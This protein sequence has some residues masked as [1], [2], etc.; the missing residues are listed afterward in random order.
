MD[1]SLPLITTLAIAFGF[2]LAFGF[3]V[4]RFLKAPALVGY[5]IAGIMAGQYTPGPV[6]D[7]ALASQLSE[8]GVILL[9][10]GVGLHFSVKD[11][12]KVKTIAIPGAILQ[13]TLATI[14]GMAFAMLVWDWSASAGLV[15]GLC[16]SCA[17]TVVLLKAMEMQGKLNTIDGQ[18][19]VGWLVVEDMATVMILVLLPPVAVIL[20]GADTGTSLSLPDMAWVMGKTIA[21]VA[22]FV[23][24]MLLF[25]RRILPWLLWQVAKTG[26]RELFTLFLL[27]GSI[28]IAYGAAYIFDV[29]FALGAFFAGM[30]IRESQY[31]KR[32]AEDSLPL[33][34]A[35]SVLFFVGVGM[36]LDW[37][38]FIA[39][40]VVILVMLSIIIL[41]KGLVAMVL[42]LLL[43]Y[44]LHTSM[45]VA[46]SLA[47]IGEFSYILA[48]QGIAL[49]MIDSSVM[50]LIVAASILSIALNPGLFAIMPYIQ[51][52]LTSR[53]SWARKAA[54]RHDPFT[55]LPANTQKHILQGQA[56]LV[57]A[58]KELDFLACALA[59]EG[60]P[61][62]CIADQKET[63]EELRKKNY[64]AIFGNPDDETVLQ[65]A[66]LSQATLLVVAADDPVKT[67]KTI[68]I[69]RE[70]KKDIEIMV[71]VD[72][73]AERSLFTSDG[74]RHVFNEQKAIA[75][76]FAAAVA[77]TYNGIEQAAANSSTASEAS[78]SSAAPKTGAATQTAPSSGFLQR[79]VQKGKSIVRHNQ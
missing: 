46:T 61:F 6:A 34:D 75:A 3:L 33:Q 2:A 58:P 44:P 77:Q 21:R 10:F 74:V 13:M 36:M 23:A 52:K 57:G 56:V 55:I 71:R 45:T 40:P 41:G 9:M 11:L 50:S 35:F 49:K 18:V 26:S 43:R 73:E 8:I 69:A 70:I 1:H 37:H 76:A 48:A 16:L 47:Q 60:I 12:L 24:I 22:A 59:T 20:Q 27:A 79:I 28:G 68:D 32:A 25:G 66:H 63:V 7:S 64:A 15:F 31:A 62:V 42:V 29:S 78:A 51:K 67:R 4:E 14:L 38:A 39:H 72:S 19:A 65:K 5:L 53:F 54:G 30:V 17:S